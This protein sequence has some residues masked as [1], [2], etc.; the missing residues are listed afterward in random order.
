MENT[1][2]LQRHYAYQEFFQLELLFMTPLVWAKSPR[3]YQPHER[4]PFSH[5]ERNLVYKVLRKYKQWKPIVNT[6]VGYVI[7]CF[8]QLK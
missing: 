2:F 7:I 3:L 5:C 4:L 6:I 1:T 8:V